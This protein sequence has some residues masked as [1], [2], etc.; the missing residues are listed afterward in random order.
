MPPHD[1]LS[2]TL[3]AA[4]VE[5]RNIAAAARARNIAPSALSKRI[6]DLEDRFGALLFRRL[7]DGVEP[8]AAG[9]ALYG[10][11]KRVE[12]LL[13]EADAEL[14]GFVKGARGHVRLWA[15][16]SALAQFL[17]EDLA[18]YAQRHPDVRIELKT[19]ASAAIVNA[20]ASG[21]ADVGIYSDHV[22]PTA[23]RER[24]YRRDTL[25][26]VSPAGHP[27]AGLERATLRDLSDHPIVALG[28]GSS[29]RS[30]LE[31]EMEALG[32]PLRVKIEVLD[33][34]AVR[35][36]VA[37]GL[38]VSVLPSGAV[39]P[40]LDGELA[41]ASTPLDEPGARRS[42]MIGVCPKRTLT[43]AA[44]DLVEAIAP[45]PDAGGP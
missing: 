21:E 42:L 26:V 34:D 18:L 39:A 9:E 11:V 4:V 19:E 3:F 37:A 7:R 24:V 35:G 41:I 43:T 22:G 17:P 10:H 32:L 31:A 33:F 30:R 25:V 14:A 1:L 6:A 36:L 16:W 20:V 29:L 38:G 23:L 15:N 5:H 28:G 40:H 2:L 44:H 12:N 27:L 45:R 8:T 13:A